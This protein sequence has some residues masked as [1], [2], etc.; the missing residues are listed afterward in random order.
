MLRAAGLPGDRRE[1]HK[2]KSTINSLRTVSI[3]RCNLCS[4]VQ[5]I[6]NNGIL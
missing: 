3:H 5:F 2:G 4:K 6:V 1:H